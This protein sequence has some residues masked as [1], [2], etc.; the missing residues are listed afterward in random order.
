[1]TVGVGVIGT[2]FVA[3]MHLAAI[4]RLPGARLVGVADVDASRARA[5]VRG[6]TDAR[7]TTSVAELLAWPDVDGCIVCTPNDTHVG[8][9]GLAAG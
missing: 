2:G 3:N 6:V 4:A 7:W 1:V 8:H 5:A 9:R